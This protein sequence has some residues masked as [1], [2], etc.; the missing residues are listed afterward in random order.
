MVQCFPY[1]LHKFLIIL[2]LFQMSFIRFYRPLACLYLFTPLL[3]CRIATHFRHRFRSFL[4]VFKIKSWSVL[5]FI[6][7]SHEF[8]AKPILLTSWS[9]SFTTINLHYMSCNFQSPNLSINYIF[10]TYLSEVR[11][12]IALATSSSLQIFWRGM[13]RAALYYRLAFSYSE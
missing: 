8:L 13:L 1:I 5:L 11:K 7:S 10:S 4:I 6:L 2:N 9:Q 3:Y 12:I